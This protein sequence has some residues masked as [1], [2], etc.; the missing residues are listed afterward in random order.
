M[1]PMFGYKLVGQFDVWS[2]PAMGTYLFGVFGLL[3]LVGFW[4]TWR[5]VSGD[6][7]QST[8]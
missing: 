5:Q 2:Y 1:P 6:Q 7:S 8:V 4:L 3:L